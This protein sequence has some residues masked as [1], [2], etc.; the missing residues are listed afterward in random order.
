MVPICLLSFSTDGY[1][2]GVGDSPVIV[3][4]K[5]PGYYPIFAQKSSVEGKVR[6][7]VPVDD[8]GHPGLPEVI[9]SIHPVLS[10]GA[11]WA[12]QKS[13]YKPASKNGIPVESTIE[14]SFEFVCPR[15]SLGALNIAPAIVISP[16]RFLYKI[17]DNQICLFGHWLDGEIEV[18]NIENRVY[19]GGIRVYPPPYTAEIRSR[20]SD[21]QLLE[22]LL[23]ECNYLQRDLLI[24]GEPVE[25]IDSEVFRLIMGFP[26]L[27]QCTELENGHY[28]VEIGDSTAEIVILKKCPPFDLSS[29]QERV[30]LWKSEGQLF[31]WLSTIES[32][33]MVFRSH[34]GTQSLARNSPSAVTIERHLAD[35]RALGRSVFWNS[36]ELEQLDVLSSI[37]EMLREPGWVFRQ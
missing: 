19:V 36:I 17:R 16:R 8:F 35:R 12:A 3:V 6:L 10:R 27:L 22:E 11:I 15:D 37:R 21:A 29:E 30:S 2:V 31:R 13:T 26:A 32:G 23:S 4:N 18:H 7:L 34:F 33:N 28:Y 25:F 1:A 24:L 5:E 20:F 9:S 14:L